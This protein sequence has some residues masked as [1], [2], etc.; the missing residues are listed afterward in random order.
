MVQGIILCNFHCVYL[1]NIGT[2]INCFLLCRS[3]RIYLGH[4]KPSILATLVI[5]VLQILFRLILR[6][7]GMFTFSISSSFLLLIYINL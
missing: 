3:G 4:R 2:F 6:V 1:M 7:L 5:L